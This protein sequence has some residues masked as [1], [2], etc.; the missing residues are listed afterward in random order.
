MVLV[1]ES[2][3]DV[4]RSQKYWWRTNGQF[5][6]AYSH[7]DRIPLD[8]YL[9]LTGNTQTKNFSIL[10][11]IDKIIPGSS[12][13]RLSLKFSFENISFLFGLFCMLLVIILFSD[14]LL[15]I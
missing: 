12:P 14:S 1:C 9:C 10:C 13:P 6:V 2:L 5:G 8:Y 11:F 7:L 3:Q 15:S 4:G